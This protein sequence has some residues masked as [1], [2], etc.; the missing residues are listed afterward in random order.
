VGAISL[1]MA[2]EKEKIQVPFTDEQ[3]ELLADLD[4]I[5]KNLYVFKDSLEKKKW[6]D[7]LNKAE[8]EVRAGRNYVYAKKLMERVKEVIDNL[9]KRIFRWQDLQKR[10]T[11]IFVIAIPLELILICFYTYFFDIV[12]YGI[13]TSMLFGLLGGSF[14]V[15]LN[16]GKDLKVEASNKLQMLRMILRP[17]VGM[18]SAIVLYAFLQVKVLVVASNIDTG[19]VI[20]LISIFGGFSERFVVKMLSNYVPTLVQKKKTKIESD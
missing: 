16:I 15:A 19:S 20:I 8:K 6:D 5:R 12:K 9:W 7:L 17:F 2:N 3:Q 13:Y 14:G 10:L 18:I 11:L 1:E 4:I